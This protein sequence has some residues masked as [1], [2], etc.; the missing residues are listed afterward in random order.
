MIVPQARKSV[1]AGV[2]H[3]NAYTPTSPSGVVGVFAFVSNLLSI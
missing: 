1:I 2:T 3:P